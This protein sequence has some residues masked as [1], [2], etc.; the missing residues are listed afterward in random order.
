MYG[1]GEC[2]A[3]A[4]TKS[5]EA[6]KRAKAAFEAAPDGRSLRFALTVAG[7]DDVLRFQTEPANAPVTVEVE[8]DGRPLPPGLLYL[9][10]KREPGPHATG[11]PS[12]LL[13]ALWLVRSG[14]SVDDATRQAAIVARGLVDEPRCLAEAL[15]QLSRWVNAQKEA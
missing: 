5:P 3:Y 14:Q 6:K 2:F 11:G 9:G 15:T 10:P 4:A 1:A 7:D 12:D 8:R 13:D